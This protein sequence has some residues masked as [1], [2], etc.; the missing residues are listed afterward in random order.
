M[1]KALLS[2][3][4]VTLSC[5]GCTRGESNSLDEIVGDSK[6]R[7]SDAAHGS[8]SR[9]PETVRGDL[10]DLASRLEDFSRQSAATSLNSE[11]ADI[12]RRILALVPH[13][14]FTSRPALTQ[15][16]TQYAAFGNVEGV[17]TEQVEAAASGSVGERQLLSARTFSA[18][19]AELEGTAFSL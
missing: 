12:S 5:I 9:V 11:A 15:L 10:S 14:G 7:F 8:L 19:A 16:A 6:A 1:N 4:F 2:A 17:G 13:S 18:L 3:L